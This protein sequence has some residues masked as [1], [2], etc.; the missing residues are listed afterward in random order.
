MLEEHRQ[1][2]YLANF[3]DTRMPPLAGTKTQQARTQTHNSLPNIVSTHT[4]KHTWF[5]CDCNEKKKDSLKLLRQQNPSYHITHIPACTH[6]CC[7]PYITPPPPFNNSTAN[8]LKESVEKHSWWLQWSLT[9][10]LTP[11]IN[12]QLW[13]LFKISLLWF[14]VNLW[15][16][17]GFFNVW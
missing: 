16:F 17:C 15:L 10:S 11:N 14:Q 13:L 6:L 8:G 2:G 9:C 3:R 12:L 7:Y 1:K 4:H 5:L